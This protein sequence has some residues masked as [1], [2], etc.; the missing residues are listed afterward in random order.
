VSQRNAERLGLD[1]QQEQCRLIVEAAPNGM[2][3]VDGAGIITLA[4]SRVDAI[5]GYWSGG[6]VGG[7]VDV[8]VP[9]MARAG[10]AAKRESFANESLPRAMADQRQLEGRRFDGSRFPIEIMLNPVTTT[11]GRIVV[12]SVAA[13]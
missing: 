1:R 4:N 8:L 9:E 2:L 5:F 12:A 11:N 10:H 7:S 13:A 6:L 3:I